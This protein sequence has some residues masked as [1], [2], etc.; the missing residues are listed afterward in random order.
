[1]SHS[2]HVLIPDH[3]LQNRRDS[4][5]KEA[6]GL[7]HDDNAAKILAEGSQELELEM[8]DAWLDDY[9]TVVICCCLFL[10]LLHKQDDGCLFSCYC[11]AV[12]HSSL[13]T[14]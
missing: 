10:L 9:V 12:K 8:A 1:M 13:S 3:W 11:E 6:I 7:A 4:T 14:R 2:S 5:T